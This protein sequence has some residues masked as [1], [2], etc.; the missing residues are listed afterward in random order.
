MS[1]F[2]EKEEIARIL[3]NAMKK[4]ESTRPDFDEGWMDA[5][6][7]IMDML[8]AIHPDGCWECRYYTP[9]KK[10]YEQAGAGGTCN[11]L[12]MDTREYACCSYGE[13]RHEE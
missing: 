12:L 5:C 1:K 10:G 9:C 11:A 4:A 6:E 7:Y 2:V 8:E 3:S 13:S